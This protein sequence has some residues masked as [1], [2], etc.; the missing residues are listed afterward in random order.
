[1]N[2]KRALSLLFIVFV[3]TKLFYLVGP[4]F[5]FE[6]KPLFTADNLCQNDCGWYKKI[7][8]QGYTHYNLAE[9]WPEIKGKVFQSEWA[10]FPLYPKIIAAIMKF[11]GQR[12]ESAALWFSLISSA[13][14]FFMLFT[15]ASTWFGS[16]SKAF[17]TTLLVMLF[18]FH[19]YFSAYYTESLFYLLLLSGFYLIYIQKVGIGIV[20]ISAL[21]PL[22]R[23]NGLIAVAFM[24]L[25]YI[26]R[27]HLLKLQNLTIKKMAL[28]GVFLPALLSFAAWCWYQYEVTGDYM[29]FN[30]VQIGW[31]RK[32]VFPWASLFNMDRWEVKLLSVYVILGLLFLIK[33]WGR[34]PWSW[35]WFC[36]IGILLPLTA[37][38][39][40][41]LPRYA[42]ILFPLFFI[43]TGT[44]TKMG[45]VKQLLSYGLLLFLQLW[46][47]YF[48]I[49]GHPIS[50]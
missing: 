32:F 46:G 8:T 39:V 43:L 45:G 44:L 34:M 47:Y 14:A 33:Q 26:E 20:L 16:V 13:A 10:F 41:S 9:K 23:V 38:S 4:G 3:L 40:L 36:M 11:T 48:F 31:D 28:L 7:A 24:A 30:K 37:G 42:S 22:L 15:F 2:K 35:W 18:P 27:N 21:L 19:F 6:G 29:T 5:V 25:Y 49:L 17:H 1:M 12:F 50:F